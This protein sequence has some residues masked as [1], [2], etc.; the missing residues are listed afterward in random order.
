VFRTNF[1]V[2]QLFIDI[3][4]AYDSV[5]RETLYT[6]FCVHLKLVRLTKICLNVTYS[7]YIKVNTYLTY[8]I[9]RIVRNKEML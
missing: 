4:K 2:H 7:E 1:T 9:F 8:F 5:M 3:K 6:E